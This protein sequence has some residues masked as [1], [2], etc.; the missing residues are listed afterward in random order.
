MNWD[1]GRPLGA[2]PGDHQGIGKWLIF[3]WLILGLV[4][5]LL[6]LVVQPN[7]AV[8]VV[9]GSGFILVGLIGVGMAAGVIP[10]RGRKQ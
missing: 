10:R 7:R 3:G 8:L 9:L 1:W 6:G 4:S 2:D 5:L